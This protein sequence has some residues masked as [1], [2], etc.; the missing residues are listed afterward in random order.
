[1][2]Q[3]QTPALSSISKGGQLTVPAAVR[4]R[5]GTTRVTVDDRGDELVVRPVPEDPIR[6]ARGML[7]GKGRG[8]SSEQLRSITRQEEQ[9]IAARQTNRRTSSRPKR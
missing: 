6:A 7:K 5:W 3:Y 1:M 2:S 9:V 8:L 4:H